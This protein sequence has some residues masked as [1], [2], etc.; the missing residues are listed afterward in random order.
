MYQII[1]SKGKYWVGPRLYWAG[2]KCGEK[3]WIKYFW[4]SGKKITETPDENVDTEEEI[5]FDDLTIPGDYSD[6]NILEEEK[7]TI[8]KNDEGWIKTK[9]IYG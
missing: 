6:Y 7:E 2:D 1:R 5:S 4:I 9:N 8:S 3:N